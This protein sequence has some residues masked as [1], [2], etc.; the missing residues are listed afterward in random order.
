M[1][2]R[3]AIGISG[4]DAALISAYGKQ[5]VGSGHDPLPDYDVPLEIHGSGFSSVYKLLAPWVKRA[6]QAGKPLLKGKIGKAAAGAVAAKGAEMLADRISGRARTADE[7][8]A[9]PGKTVLDSVLQRGK[10]IAIDRAQQM[11]KLGIDKTQALVNTQI[12]SLQAKANEK[13]DEMQASAQK[14]AASA[15]AQVQDGI[16]AV[17]GRAWSR[18]RAQQGSGVMNEEGAFIQGFIGSGIRFADATGGPRPGVRVMS[19]T[20]GRFRTGRYMGA[21]PGDVRGSGMYSVGGGYSYGSA[22][23]EKKKH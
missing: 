15:Q 9:A 8:H 17:K 1:T 3:Y 21:S 2:K 5:M 4:E 22:G 10:D 6:W 19:S 16:S 12:D 7:M 20:P 11:A 23:G 18:R 14:V 13:I